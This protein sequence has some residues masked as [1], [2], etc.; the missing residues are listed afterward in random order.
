MVADAG[1]VCSTAICYHLPCSVVIHS[2]SQ[3]RYS[4]KMQTLTRRLC[5]ETALGV[6]H[7][8]ATDDRAAASTTQ[9]WTVHIYTLTPPPL[10]RFSLTVMYLT[11]HIGTA[12]M[13]TALKPYAM[14]VRASDRVVRRAAAQH[15]KLL[16][17]IEQQ[18]AHGIII[19]QPQFL[20][21]TPGALNA[22]L[23]NANCVKLLLGH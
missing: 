6:L 2:M 22:Q 15:A 3:E 21:S 20:D 5:C 11:A 14:S 17:S 9:A 18:T 13:H 4:H 16:M 12:Q 1:V 23:H 10:S 19:G 8:P 7:H